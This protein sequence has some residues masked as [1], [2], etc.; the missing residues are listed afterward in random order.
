M[1]KAFTSEET[2]DTSVTGRPAVRA[3]RGQERPITPQGHR[4]LVDELRQLTEVDRPRLKA[5][6]DS[7]DRLRVLDARVA[8]VSATLQSV[9]VVQPE[10]VNDGVVRFGS[11]VTLR[12]RTGRSQTV[13]LVGPDE[14]D[15]KG[16]RVSVEAPLARAM[17]EQRRGDTI[18]L[19]RPRG[20][21]A[22]VI[23][24]VWAGD[25]SQP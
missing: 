12:W 16:G 22:A 15:V 20:V 2:E 8:T 23:E 11:T 6:P 1:S 3:A 7:A 21:E 18:E 10:V 24:A 13:R 14:A 25:D 19:E 9:R 5:E 17:L 4:A